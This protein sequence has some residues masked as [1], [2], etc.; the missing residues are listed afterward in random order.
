MENLNMKSVIASNPQV[1]RDLHTLEEALSAIRGL[2]ENGTKSKGYDLASPFE[3][4]RSLEARR[5]VVHS[6]G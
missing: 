1:E 4:R 2:R 6:A 3:R 5:T